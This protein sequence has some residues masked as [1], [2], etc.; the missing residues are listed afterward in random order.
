MTVI[1]KTSNALFFN[2]ISDGVVVPS[3]AFANTGT[4]G[5]TGRSYGAAIGDSQTNS[6]HVSSAKVSRA[7]TIEAWVIPDCG[8]VIA[9]KEGLFELRIGDIG[10]PGPAQF[11]VEVHDNET[12]RQSISVA[13]ASP[14][15]AAGS[16]NGWDGI[17]YPT[18]ANNTMHGSFNQFNGAL[19]ATS[20]SNIN[21]RPLIHVCGIFT[22]Q[23]VKL[24][25]N[26]ELVSSE[27]LTNASRLAVS[28]SNLYIGGKGGEY[29]GVIEGLHW[30]RGFNESGIRPLPLVSSGDTIALWR[31]EE[32][33]EVPQISLNLKTNALANA[34]SWIISEQD[35]K[36]LVS[37][38]TGQTPTAA[39]TV[40]LLGDPYSNGTYQTPYASILQHT[41]INLIINPTGTD[42]STGQ[43]YTVS[44]PERVRLTS[45]AYIVG[46]DTTL[47]INSIHLG[48]GGA[49]RGA[50][51][52]HAGF[53]TT[54]HK[55]LGSTIVLVNS[56]SLLDIS[57]G[58]PYLAP[59]R[60]T[61]VIDRT[62][63]MVVDEVNGNHGFIFSRQ[64]S[65][66]TPYTFTWPSTLEEGH[67]AGHTGRHKYTQVSGHPFLRVLPPAVEETVNRNLDGDTDT[68][69]AYFDGG[70]MGLREQI[71]IG[72][73]LDMHRQAYSG[74]SLDTEI[75]SNV[76]QV[77]EN[78]MVGIDAS[79][80][81][82]IGIGGPDFNPIPFLL[83]GHAAV[84]ED[85]TYNSYDIHLT[86]ED[87]PR[88]A[89]LGVSGLTSIA[90]YVEIHY[91]AIDLTGGTINNAAI[92]LAA[93]AWASPDVVLKTNMV[94]AFGPNA[95]TIDAYYIKAGG[96][97][98]ALGTGTHTA[99]IDYGNNKL[100]F[101]AP[102]TLNVAFTGA[103]LTDAKIT[104]ELRGA[105]LCVTKTV[106]DAA[107]IIDG[108]TV[109]EH[110]HDAL[111]NGEL[112]YSPG[113][114]IRISDEDLGLGSVVFEPHRLVGDNTGGTTYELELNTSKIANDYMPTNATDAPIT[115]PLGIMASHVLDAEH[116]SRYHKLIVRASQG[117]TSESASAQTIDLPIESAPSAF[118]MSPIQESSTNDNGVFDTPPSNQGS[119][120]FELFDIIDNWQDG[121]EHIIIIQPT[122]RNRTIQLARFIGKNINPSNHLFVSI[123]YMQCRGRLEEFKDGRTSSG[124]TLIMRGQGLMHDIRNSMTNYQGDG[125]PDS[126]AIKEVTPGGPVV[127]ISLGGLGQGAK[128]TKPTY[129]PSP[130]ARIG[131]NT[132]RPCGAKVSYTGF[133]PAT[134]PATIQV[135]PLNNN[136]S[137][138]ASWGHIC[139]PP[140]SGASGAPK[141]RIYLPSGAS[142]A[143]FD[144]VG[145]VFQF[146]QTDPKSANSWFLGANG[147]AY[148]TFAAWVAA[149]SFIEG[150]PIYTD[151]LIGDESQCDDGTTVNDRM[152]QKLDSV[153]H[154]YQLGTQ[155]AS[156]RALV[157][158]PLFPNQFFENRETYTF[159]GPD[160]SMKITLDATMT[161][162]TYAPNPV[163]IKL[164]NSFPAA[165]PTATGPYDHIFSKS[166]QT[167][168]TTVTHSQIKRLIAT[169]APP[170]IG[171]MT[172]NLVV[173]VENPDV[174]PDAKG[175]A[176]GYAGV[177]GTFGS[178]KVFLAN[179]EWAY[180]INVD[181]TNK[182]L[183]I[184][185]DMSENFIASLIAGTKISPTGLT[186]YQPNTPILADGH[187]V[188][189]A[190]GQEFPSASHYDR[191]S[192]QTQGG[193]IDYG[194]KEY[195][196][197]VEFKSGPRENP[198]LPKMKN[199]SWTGTMEMGFAATGGCLIS[200]SET[201]PRIGAAQYWG[202]HATATGVWWKIRHNKTGVMYA[203][204]AG[205]IKPNGLEHY[206]GE[207]L[208]HGLLLRNWATG[209]LPTFAA[210]DIEKNDSLTIV[211]LGLPAYLHGGVERMYP[212]ACLNDEWNYPYAQGGL[213]DGDTVW[214]NMHYT[215]PHATDGLF[216]K[217]RGVLNQFQVHNMFNSGEGDFGFKSRESIPMEN[218]LIGNNCRESADNF[219]QHVN[220]TV[221][222]NV[223]QLGE[224]PSS[225]RVV[226]FIDPY[227]CTDDHARV[228][229]YDLAHNREFIAFHDIHMQVQSDPDAVQID[230]LDVANGHHSQQIEKVPI[231]LDSSTSAWK[232]DTTYNKYNG[233]SSYIRI[234]TDKMRSDY[235]EGA[236]S[237]TD[238]ETLNVDRDDSADPSS[239][240]LGKW[241][242][243]AQN[244]RN[245]HESFK[246]NKDR[247][248]VR[249]KDSATS[250]SHA[251]YKIIAG[252]YNE[253][254][255][256]DALLYYGEDE[257]GAKLWGVPDINSWHGAAHKKNSTYRFSQTTFDTPHGTRVLP[258]FLCLKG[259]RMAKNTITN[260]SSN[261]YLS[262]KLLE[263]EWVDMSF[264]RRL[265]IDLGEVGTK[266]GITSI[267]SA[268]KEIVRLVNQAGAANGRSNIRKPNSQ[269][270][271]ITADEDDAAHMHTNADYAVTGSTHDPAPFWSADGQLSF[272]RG[273]HMGYLRAH[274]GRVVEDINGNEGYSI[275]IHSTVP[276]ATGRNF[277]AWLDNSRGQSVYSPQFL[278]GHGGRFRDYYCQPEEIWN[279]CMHPAPMPINK[280]GRPFAPITT[281]HELV[282]NDKPSKGI[283]TNSRRQPPAAFESEG[284]VMSPDLG[285]TGGGQSSN[286]VGTESTSPNEQSVIQGLR[287]GTTAIGRI[288]FG[289]LTATG[290]PGWSPDLGNWGFG[291]SGKDSRA[292]QIY[293]SAFSGDIIETT[294]HVPMAEKYNFESGELYAVEMEDHRGIKHRIR[295]IYKEYG[296]IFSKEN[297]VLPATMDN[298]IVIWIDDR[299]ISQGGF[300][301][302]KHMKGKGDIGG[303]IKIGE[304]WITPAG[305]LEA[306]YETTQI[307]SGGVVE[308]SYCGNRWNT[309]KS[310]I[311][312]FAVT[313]EKPLAITGTLE[314]AQFAGGPSFGHMAEGIW[315]D[316]PDGDAL[317]FLGF[318]KTNG[319]I[320]I[321]YPKSGTLHETG[322][323]G[324][325]ISYE[326]RTTFD[327]AAGPGNNHAFFGCKNIPA[328][329]VAW[330]SP[331]IG[332]MDTNQELSPVCISSRPNWTSIFT[333]ELLAAAVHRAI[334]M[335]DPNSDGDDTVFDCREMYASDGR[336]FGEWGVSENAIRIQS[337]KPENELMPLRLL[338]NATL[339]RDYGMLEAHMRGNE[340]L[341]PPIPVT[342]G[343]Q[344]YTEP[345]GQQGLVTDRGIP[346]YFID[347]GMVLPCG[348]IPKTVLNIHTTYSGTNANKPSPRIVNSSNTSIDTNKWESHLKGLEYRFMRGD[349][350]SP[351]VSNGTT[352]LI[353]PRD[354]TDTTEKWSIGTMH[355]ITAD[356]L[357]HGM[358][359]AFQFGPVGRLKTE[360]NQLSA[361][362]MF[363]AGGNRAEDVSYVEPYELWHKGHS[364]TLWP[365]AINYGLPASGKYTPQV[366]PASAPDLSYPHKYARLIDTNDVNEEN[367]DHDT[368]NESEDWGGEHQTGKFLTFTIIDDGTGYAAGDYRLVNSKNQFVAQV[369]LTAAAG[370][371][372]GLGAIVSFGVDTTPNEQLS[373]VNIAIISNE[374]AIVRVS[375]VDKINRQ[376]TT[377]QW[378]ERP[379]FEGI[380]YTASS[381]AS[382]PIL[383]FRGAKDGIDH[384]VPLYFGGGFSGAVFDIND[385]TQ[386]DYTDMYT[387]PYSAGP[388][389]TAG[390][391]NA[392]SIMGS[393]ALIDTTAIMAMFPGTPYLDQHK[394]QASSPF[395]NK[396]IVLTDD[397]SAMT[398]NVPTVAGANHRDGGVALNPTYQTQ[399]SPVVLRF[400]YPF[401][402]YDDNGG[403]H[404]TTYVIFGPGQ[405][406]PH[407]FE[408]E[409]GN[410]TLAT[411]SEPSV[412]VSLSALFSR[413]INHPTVY[414]KTVGIV[415]GTPNGVMGLP[416]VQCFMGT[417]AFAYLPNDPSVGTNTTW[418]TPH[419]PAQT[420]DGWPAPEMGFIPKG[421]N[422]GASNAAQWQRYDNWEPAQGDPNLKKYN[423]EAYYGLHLSDHFLRNDPE[424][425]Y[426]PTRS[427]PHG[428]PTTT[429]LLWSIGSTG[430]AHPHNPVPQS[431]FEN[432]FKQQTSNDMDVTY[433]IA[434][435]LPSIGFF[436]KQPTLKDFASHMDGGYLPGCNFLDDRVIR[437][438]VNFGFQTK[439]WIEAID[440]VSGQ[441]VRVGDNASMYRIAAPMLSTLPG[442]AGS[443]TWALQ[444][445]DPAQDNWVTGTKGTVD[446]DV[447]VVDA[448]RVQNAEELATVIACAINEWPGHAG[449]KALGGTFLPSFQHAHK[450]D[451]T[452]WAMLPMD[453]TAGNAALNA[454][455]D[456]LTYMYQTTTEGVQ[457]AADS[458][459]VGDPLLTSMSIGIGD[460][461]GATRFLPI[462]LPY[463][464]TGRIW[465]PVPGAAISWLSNF[466]NGLDGAVIA[467][468]V[469]RNAGPSTYDVTNHGLYFF[470]RGMSAP[471]DTLHHAKGADRSLYLGTNFRTGLRTIED[472]TLD[473]GMQICTTAGVPQGWTFPG[474]RFLDCAIMKYTHVGDPALG[475]PY[476]FI[477]TKTG[478]HRWENGALSNSASQAAIITNKVVYSLD[479]LTT[480]VSETL[481]ST[482][483]HFNGM[484]DA[485]DRTR[486]I[487]SVGWAGNQYSMLNSM[488]MW[489]TDY[490]GS[491]DMAYAIPRGLGAWHTF[492][493]FNPYGKAL[494][495]HANNHSGL[496]SDQYKRRGNEGTSFVDAVNSDTQTGGVAA[497]ESEAASHETFTNGWSSASNF[498]KGTSDGHFVV[499][500]HDN[501]ASCIARSDVLNIVGYGDRLSAIWNPS[502]NI[503]D[504]PPA[505]KIVV[506]KPGW[507][508]NGLLKKRATT[509]MSE[510]IHNNSKYTA[511]A[512]GGP[513][514]EAQVFTALPS[515]GI[516]PESNTDATKMSQGDS[517]L[518]PTGDLFLNKNWLGEAAELHADAASIG[519]IRTPQ[520]PT[521]FGQDMT[522]LNTWHNGGA[523]SLSPGALNFTTDHI[524]WK[525]MD[526]GNL[527]LP[528]PNYR[529]MGGTPKTTRRTGI[530]AGGKITYQSHATGEILYGN[531]RFSIETT[532]SAMLPVI[533]SQELA[534]PILAEQYPHEIG[535]V[536]SIPNEDIQFESISVMDD[537]GQIHTL[538]GGSPFGTVIR[539]FAPIHNRDIGSAPSNVGGTPNM[540]I[541]LPD[542][543]TI[544]G[545]IIIRSG[546]DRLQAYQN[547]TIGTGGM[548]MPNISEGY[549]AF[550]SGIGQAP[551]DIPAIFN[552]ETDTGNDLQ[553]Y[554]YWENYGYEQ[555]SIQ[556]DATS[557]A[558]ASTTQKFPFSEQ[559]TFKAATNNNPLK[560]S[561]ELHDRT[562]YFHIVQNGKSYSKL[563]NVYQGDY[564]PDGTIAK[565]AIE[566]GDVAAAY[567][568][569]PPNFAPSSSIATFNAATIVMASKQPTTMWW[570]DTYNKVRDGTN[571]HYFTAT[572]A[573]G[574]IVGG[575]YNGVSSSS[576]DTYW[577][578]T[579]TGVVYDSD[580]TM[581]AGTLATLNR[582]FY[583]PAGTTRLFASRRMRDHA[584]MSGQ[585]PD[586]P[587]ID[588]WKLNSGAS[589]N[590]HTLIKT[591]RMTKMP[592]PRMGHHFITP[593]MAMMPGHLA[594]PLYQNIFAD[595]L[596]CASAIPSM[597]S[598][599]GS[600]PPTMDPNI[601]FSNLTPNYPPSDIHGGAFTLMTETKV[602]FDGY[603]I[604]ASSGV[605]GDANA[606]GDNLIILETSSNYSLSSHFPDPLDVGAYQI[607]IQ[608]NVF[609][610]QIT[611]FHQN[612]AIGTAAHVTGAAAQLNLTGQQVATVIGI[613]NDMTTYGA[614]GLILA[615][616]I[617]ADVRGCEIYLNEL[618][619]DIDPS[620]GQQFT[621]LPPLA[622]FNPLGVNESATPPFTRRSM[623]YHTT[624]FT[625]ATPG[626]T[627]S[628]PW[629]AIPS[630]GFMHGLSLSN[631][632]TYYQFC[633]STYG[634]ISAQITLA[635]YPSYFFQPYTRELESMSP[636]CTISAINQGASTITVGDN[637]LFPVG[638]ST[639]NGQQ[640]VAYDS[641]NQRHYA[642]Y[643]SRGVRGDGVV[644]TS[645]FNG[646]TGSA[647]F[648]LAIDTTSPTY[649]GGILY[650]SGPHLNYQEGEVI[651]DRKV[652]PFTRILPQILTGSRDT[653]SLFLADAYLCLWHHNLGRPFTAF[654]DNNGA[655]RTNMIP[656]DAKPYN[657]MPESFEM[658]HYHEFAYAISSGP[659]GL[660]MKWF[661]MS[662]GDVSPT[663]HAIVPTVAAGKN[664]GTMDVGALTNIPYF[665]MSYW[666]GGTRYGGGASRLDMWGDVERGW[667]AGEWYS[668]ECHA[669]TI[670]RAGGGAYPSPTTIDDNSPVSQAWTGY[671]H[672]TDKS[673]G[674]NNCF[675]YR[676]SVRQPYNRPRWATAIK[677]LT[678]AAA[679]YA[680]NDGHY[681]YFNGPYVQ[682]E[683]QIWRVGS[684]GVTTTNHNP[685]TGIF[686]RQTNASN[687]LGLDAPNWQVR[688]SD[689]RRMTKPFGCP[690]R[691]L[692]NDS[693]VRRLYPNDS[694]GKSITDLAKAVMH[695]IVDWWGNTTGEDVR[696]FPVRSFGV[697][698]AFDPEAWQ[699]TSGA[700]TIPTTEFNVPVSP[701]PD[702]QSGT[703]HETNMAT[704]VAASQSYVD[705]FNPVD[706]VR[707]GD[708]GDGRGA[709]YPTV[710]NEYKIQSVD[711]PMNYIGMVLS[712]HTAEP[713]F[714]VGLLRANDDLLSP[715]EP[716][717][718]ISSKLG[719]S[720]TDGLLKP[721]A[722]SGQNIEATSGVF[723]MPNLSFQEHVSR[724]SPRIGVD[725]LT[726]SEYLDTD[727][728]NYII[729]ATQAISMH[730]DKAIGQ[731]YILEK[732]MAHRMWPTHFAPGT[733]DIE[734]TWDLTA[735]QW[736]QNNHE[737][738]V[739]RFN[740]AH[741][742][743]TLGG[744]FIMETSSISTPF[745]DLSWGNHTAATAGV[746]YNLGTHGP[747]SNPYQTASHNPLV[748]PTNNADLSVKFLLRPVRLLDYKHMAVFRPPNYATIGPQAEAGGKHFF[749]ATAGGRYGLYNYDAPNARA[750]SS[751]IYVHTD[752]PSPIL[753]PYAASYIPDQATWLTN[754]SQGPKLPG[755]DTIKSLS[756]S[757]TRLI[758]SEN[759]LQHHRSDAPRRQSIISGGDDEDDSVISKVYSVS[760]RYSQTLHSKGD[761]GTHVQNTPYHA[762]EADLTKLRVVDW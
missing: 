94:K 445:S 277:C 722:M 473:C 104:T 663:N 608:P 435:D 12:G 467:T 170:Y 715:N 396:D 145:G 517:C 269:Y 349:K 37:S 635:G 23:Q 444:P 83:K 451:K 491:G 712:H 233:G 186:P 48:D 671:N 707:V 180:Y 282:V 398:G 177:Q 77:I 609:T 502:V 523:D 469:E 142:A 476:I 597:D 172:S 236:Y 336:T 403:D 553:L 137:S 602:R 401:A 17:V 197:A 225:S 651:T 569:L 613:H 346:N 516:A 755:I 332:P 14:H 203:A 244:N 146:D 50:L 205:V 360:H 287:K 27:K 44:P 630:T 243:S 91:N 423:Q 33:V 334:N 272:D 160:N 641:N 103:V 471:T 99:T 134:N 308:E 410:G 2:G 733:L 700:S 709:R 437:N 58:K 322:N 557:N 468:P 381:L 574:S 757:V 670:T 539:D 293:T 7:F 302:G 127:S 340:Y 358:H 191:S 138:L 18:H 9:S 68:F 677:S 319:V 182:F 158:I 605:A 96:H 540:E 672:G 528:A 561:Y 438:S 746:A 515:G 588:W 262:T 73:I 61:Q 124:R 299:D 392:G 542:P 429:P 658:V 740:N 221:F 592:I 626:Y 548:Q 586:M 209:V 231:I 583:T 558:S 228:L 395:P 312:A 440:T 285:M 84:N 156:T 71:P 339:H 30:R 189:S 55:A 389:G 89:V 359:Q 408:P 659:F 79:Q 664:A 547:E 291:E 268:A 643:T 361:H 457:N 116:E 130:M 739:I 379:E 245:Y 455:N 112:L 688:Y 81:N 314:L 760:P 732:S 190:E 310:P 623:P 637:S 29:R 514:V 679:G 140:S 418:F 636:L 603:G 640:L 10:T 622:T 749:N 294:G 512:N 550:N 552:A 109:A 325:F 321:T 564:S 393:H 320:Q 567:L 229:L 499:I 449:L 644:D 678:D 568:D 425:N 682:A 642:T 187:G 411:L 662:V 352:R 736:R 254:Y 311:G 600:V 249:T 373:V 256:E 5:S 694:V 386:N 241:R 159:P 199:K 106:P 338:F 596:A 660:N 756:G 579:L 162:H 513:Y 238:A 224:T 720:A 179:G 649:G 527:S 347:R 281:L 223:S 482:H 629:W 460:V 447:I 534:H 627:M 741:G 701:Y 489:A 604:L 686:E 533:Q 341:D 483:V 326:S 74:A 632:D 194:L 458:H 537:T 188:S 705:W 375:T 174:F 611:G 93:S 364:H 69:M 198:H 566:D 330:P 98:A 167:M 126:H 292:H 65:S 51:H 698:P 344:V 42:I 676:F 63:Q 504:S 300:T 726:T 462:G 488:G 153:Q 185:D 497:E 463:V 511:P 150:T 204:Q 689:G 90:P 35:G 303:R 655:G 415:P 304:Q 758:V 45:V 470:Y 53:D 443:D 591:P 654:S 24:Y 166:S 80:R 506:G 280:D 472:S 436:T 41:P 4:T 475:V 549:G 631:A 721:Q 599:I 207:E 67:K 235:I 345:Q 195:V 619:L 374:N 752:N 276:G 441:T 747:T 505:A 92:G 317:G 508:A 729:Q 122:N 665:F 530:E 129:D 442:V 446:R 610:Q 6:D 251:H 144:I 222:M 754:K 466:S 595:H 584:E 348:Y 165:D 107:S 15:V 399:P 580:Y 200:N 607:I 152:F 370:A 406:V 633:R 76:H 450:Q 368:I 404:Q 750:A 492:L 474:G 683:N 279:Q 691:T 419:T 391:Q 19:N 669:Y 216:C 509:W 382:K 289:G 181:R 363:Y 554:P 422:W 212:D 40:D 157:E 589:T 52:A 620:P 318:P 284:E 226:A 728:D 208:G 193:N 278:I 372:T 85:G 439:P 625:R 176:A 101:S 105:S 556:N 742:L 433:G 526:G 577:V 717:R 120:L 297:T 267:E 503:L 115:P 734:S 421:K 333:D 227:L 713:P 687:L 206:P 405:S 704:Y 97:R 559:G 390:I 695:Y 148:P 493:R 273:S 711:T 477:N 456:H 237:H 684:G 22:G 394:G 263:P 544:P 576:G 384:T 260:I 54:N 57:T 452:A 702:W 648:W 570:D 230:N 214:M 725:A 31:F 369:T 211:G 257:Y 315:H 371:I 498:P 387:H 529:G 26:G 301:I 434:T 601:W 246:K 681:G 39:T 478:N 590:P 621:S 329:L 614:L 520:R 117:G 258:A 265:T 34:T 313:L 147:I 645:R 703:I 738:G 275:V 163:G 316:L 420:Q 761:D 239:N 710:F 376:W 266:E 121:K 270:P 383:Y 131:W 75:S 565:C 560:T 213:R 480:N 72:T 143:Y 25:V 737:R 151:P 731:R 32:P 454:R 331:Q 461:G 426:T 136:S 28:T 342:Y 253:T 66:T 624:M 507:T 719:L 453:H 708:R 578:D 524:V 615:D 168:S 628:I 11:T 290:I 753:A 751:G 102:G 196:S 573:D 407:M 594:H 261:S 748:L 357:A 500:S 730:N 8:G 562:L 354:G 448:T 536:L 572:L 431:W 133:S 706:S 169:P 16:H 86:P 459:W 538:E 759:T 518:A 674:R 428:A 606:L 486:P 248:P 587:T 378:P 283:A 232:E 385:G 581:T 274:I 414:P 327:K 125:S 355:G 397:M 259:I 650:L 585:S 735:I 724:I 88:V 675:G 616:P 271:G 495:C 337:F 531:C 634:A 324:S 155:Y 661:D 128:D 501:E 132:R 484:H 295:I 87:E 119:N 532:N 575:S 82:I 652:S 252:M 60:G 307:I 365:Y 432:Q 350:I 377:Q 70:S 638:G 496:Y 546:F 618:M 323:T 522:P 139:F 718:G 114:I 13:S 668:G 192:V 427:L 242:Y 535:D 298:E 646:V 409:R 49:L 693:S 366:A 62:G 465:S 685:Y 362:H 481:A 487:G 20:N 296:E 424:A 367:P 210:P 412:A 555:I 173:Y 240:V 202:E 743:P 100:V 521:I 149:T 21:T 111:A 464:G 305:C 38:I 551:Q 612:N 306:A 723:G 563:E 288:N 639:I 356:A 673:W 413:D 161:A 416:S 417:P 696:R 201:F 3:S 250:L 519:G 183:N 727:P 598:A 247:E 78:G 95:G 541:Q 286:T 697:R 118:I 113:G 56:D 234:R 110:I 43:P 543:D 716:P 494:Q 123:E 215:N 353:H 647:A 264:T 593:T 36:E 219:A 184:S 744:N 108:K 490:S 175:L 1:G 667:N 178:R 714:T 47:T 430:Y 745:N 402:R 656:S 380:R 582:S 657:S 335:D 64:I 46:G 255:S 510:K 220:Q 351:N 154:D 400:A 485:V 343:G 309:N 690:V 692:R 164:G 666:P 617:A 525:R 328:A 217:S 479:S 571:R 141:S 171:G 762:D 680:A 545:N 59:N 699:P 135:I 388:S 653:N 218:F